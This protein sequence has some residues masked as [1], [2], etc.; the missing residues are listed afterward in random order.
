MEDIIRSLNRVKDKLYPNDDSVF[1]FYLN[2]TPANENTFKIFKNGEASLWLAKKTESGIV[3]RRILMVNKV[4][5]FD[6][7]VLKD[8]IRADL[9]N[10]FTTLL[11]DWLSSGGLQKVMEE[12]GTE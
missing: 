7:P 9:N 5:R 3:N 4:D 1:I 8:S 11:I 12:N 10:D 6:D 2:F